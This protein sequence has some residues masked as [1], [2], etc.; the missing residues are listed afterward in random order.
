MKALLS[1]VVIAFLFISEIKAQFE[2]PKYEFGVRLSGL[3]YQGDLS[4]SP[5]GSI[6][7]PTIGAGFFLTRIINKSISLRTNVDF[8]S[9]TDDDSKYSDPV[10]KP[11][12]NLQFKTSFTDLSAHI[13]YHLKNNYDNNGVIPYFFTGVGVS[14]INVTRNADSFNYAFHDWQSWVIPGLAKDLQTTPPKSILFIPAGFGFKCSVTPNLS[15]L[16]EATF[17]FMFTDYL[18]GFSEVAH[19]ER[20]DHYTNIS[21]GVLYRFGDNSMACPRY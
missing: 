14:F 5:L 4:P 13:V 6:K 17:R 19:K 20:N 11:E 21:L 15:L 9:L 3:I 2:L 1:L 10:W 12:R 16:G 18:D 7:R 8:G